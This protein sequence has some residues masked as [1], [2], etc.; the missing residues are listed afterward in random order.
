[1]L[2]LVI[3]QILALV[4][5]A[6][7][8]IHHPNGIV[9]LALIR[10]GLY[11]FFLSVP[12]AAFLVQD[13]PTAH[14]NRFPVRA[15]A[16]IATFLLVV[17]GIFAPSGLS[18]LSVSAKVETA[19]L[20]MTVVGVA[21]AAYAMV[22][23]GMN[24]SFWPEARQLVVGGP[25]RFVRHPVYLAEIVMSCAVVILSMRLTLVIGECVVIVLQ[26]VR[27][28]AEERLLA[29]TFPTFKEIQRET[30]YR[31]IPGVW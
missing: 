23:L 20:V 30:P 4:H 27:I 24:F 28:R 21:F 6:V 7:G 17:L 29:G 18:L 25:Y 8:L 22:S 31:L 15:A 11:A 9:I 12:V 26:I 1:L 19:A 13:P 5:D 10:G 14:D 16:L 3:W 2:L